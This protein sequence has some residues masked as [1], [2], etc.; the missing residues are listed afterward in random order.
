MC[1]DEH[2]QIGHSD[3]EHE[4]CPLCRA[5]A[6]LAA[7]RDEATKLRTERDF[8]TGQARIWETS[9]DAARSEATNLRADRDAARKDRDYTQ[10][11]LRLAIDGHDS[12]IKSYALHSKQVLAFLDNLPMDVKGQR[13][14][15]PSKWRECVKLFEPEGL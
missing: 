5:I 13:W 9:S 12:Y 2:L 1:R 8:E 7:A 15:S 10:G 11:E 14:M 3:S 6:E 4:M